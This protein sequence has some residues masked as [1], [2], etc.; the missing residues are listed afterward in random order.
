MYQWHS[1]TRSKLSNCTTHGKHEKFGNTTTTTTTTS[2]DNNNNNNNNNG[3]SN[4][5]A[6]NKKYKTTSQHKHSRNQNECSPDHGLFA[7]IYR[8]L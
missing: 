5:K 8:S 7:C 4:H 6:H 3:D 1:K 2:N